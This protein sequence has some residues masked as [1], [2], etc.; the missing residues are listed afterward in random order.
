MASKGKITEIVDIQACENQLTSLNKGLLV[1]LGTIEKVSK[2]ALTMSNSFKEAKGIKDIAA[3]T[4]KLNK[5]E[6]EAAVVNERL[7]QQII[8]TEKATIALNNAKQKQSEKTQKELS[9]YQKLSNELNRTRENARN[10]AAQYGI[11]D[12]RSRAAAAGVQA[13]DKKLKEIDATLG[14]HQRNVGNYS[15]ALGG[16]GGQFGSL[17]M[18]IERYTGILAGGM[19]GL[20]AAFG[21][22]GSALKALLLNP[23]F[24]AVGAMAALFTSIKYVIKNSMEYSKTMSSVKAVTSATAEEMKLLKEN[25]QMLGATTLK[26][27]TEVAKLQFE[28]AK[29]GFTVPQIVAMTE[30]V[31]KLSIASGSE[32][33]RS[34]EVLGTTMRSIGLGAEDGGRVADVMAKSFMTSALDMEKWAESFKYVGAVAKTINAPLEET[35]A[36]LAVLANAGISGSNA[37]T[38]LRMIMLKLGEQSGTLTE[39]I[40]KLQEQGLGLADAND[41]VGQRAMT[42]L[43]ILGQQKDMLPEFT[44]NFE[45]AAGSV[46]KM[47]KIM[48]DNLTGDITLL[49]SAWDGLMMSI[50]D[51]EG[52]LGS[53]ARAFIQ[54][55]T[56]LIDLFSWVGKQ[57]GLGI[58][59]MVFQFDVLGK[60]ITAVGQTTDLVFSAIAK[61]WQALT[62]LDFNGVVDAFDGLGKS[63]AEAWNTD[64]WRDE[65]NA[66]NAFLKEHKAAEKALAQKLNIVTKGEEKISEKESDEAF[67][68][69]SEK[70]KIRQQ[71]L[72]L[73]RDF[74]K[75]A[76]NIIDD[77]KSGKYDKKETE[78]ADPNSFNPEITPEE[79]FIDY[80]TEALLQAYDEQVAAAEWKRDKLIEIGQQTYDGLMS[81]VNSQYASQLAQIDQLA[82]ADEEAKQKELK[83]AGD[84]KAAKDAIEA[85]YLAKEKERE[86]ERIK[87]KMKQD[88]ANKAAAMIKVII[89]T[90]L[91][92]VSALSTVATAF[93]APIIAAQGAIQ[94]GVIAATPLPKYFK[95]REGGKA[96]FALVGERGKEAIQLAGGETFLTP[97]KPTVT[98][99]PEG[100]KVITN[101]KLM[102]AAEMAA[103]KNM[104]SIGEQKTGN[105]IQ[106]ERLIDAINNKKEYHINL[107]EKGL[108]MA[109][110][111][112]QS[113]TTYLNQNVRI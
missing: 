87:I 65:I 111:R 41:E 108:Q 77:F 86:A 52:I 100:A 112:G 74:Y 8:A 53:M 109:A 5:V 49:G 17:I 37:G 83:Q 6:L 36:M 76:S 10:L 107:T 105:E 78:K 93:M 95:G 103:F 104:P 33:G 12:A 92:I 25:A 110:K 98:W 3:S 56:D 71:E 50:E 101:E 72:D 91:G 27:A 81:L 18:S 64:R 28:L 1:V 84:N 14:Q 68:R 102:A 89:D 60:A 85:K 55:L 69:F 88:K 48:A 67:K 29:L 16:M 45:D 73:E 44:M 7:K 23:I 31:T 113:V 43:L 106:I 21:S 35:A 62:N 26:T 59:F 2:N 90:A 22:L 57:F 9:E 15:Q 40:T 32:M 58:D 47:S 80:E 38:A 30:A 54:S 11:N 94:L 51:G 24:L 70:Q 19:S 20:K 46:D 61:S 42:A 66:D 34:A 97:D 63:I 82:K 96:E 79:D 75:T 13:L 4:E 39:K 99:L